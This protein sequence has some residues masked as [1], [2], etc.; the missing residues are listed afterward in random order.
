[1]ESKVL[2]A[3][4]LI[5]SGP[6]AVVAQTSAAD[7]EEASE[8]ARRAAMAAVSGPPRVFFDALAVDR[9]LVRRVGARVWNSLTPRQRS[10][11]SAAMKDRVLGALAPGRRSAAEIA[12]SSAEPSDSGVDVFL[13]ISFGEKVLKTRWKMVRD[14]PRWRIIDIV[15]IDPGISLAGS[16]LHALGPAPVQ[17]RDRARQAWSEAYPRAA[18]LAV[19][20]LVVLLAAPRLPRSKRTL[21]I[22]TASA[23]AALFALDGILAVR[24]A[25]SETYSL[26]MAPPGEPWSR[27]EQIALR[28]SREGRPEQA[29][30]MWRRALAAGEPPGPVEY[31]VGL[32]AREAGDEKEARAAFERALAQKDPAPGAARE[33]AA[34]DLAAGRNAEALELARR[35]RALAGPDP[36]ALSL[37]AVALTNLGRASEAIA[38]IGQARQLL[39]EAARGAELEARIRARAGDALGAVAALKQ[40]EAG[41]KLDREVLRSDPSYLPI[42]TDPEWVKFLDEK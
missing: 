3:A 26:A 15:L 2:L 38:V 16:A 32:S 23:P 12:W 6:A 10:Q 22:L 33:L 11:L 21:L 24:R 1:M 36:D 35:Y 9:L 25:L 40:L 31:Q 30:A 34:L 17:V 19:I 28:E 14:G 5:L 29:S 18:S 27:F 8:L 42:A 37:E 39:A 13:G 20:L 41:G 7:L 4:W